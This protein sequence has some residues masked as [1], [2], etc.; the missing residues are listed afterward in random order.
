MSCIACVLK[1][2]FGADDGD[3]YDDID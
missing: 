3:D 1:D 2:S